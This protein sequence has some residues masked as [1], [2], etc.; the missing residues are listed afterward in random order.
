MA[1]RFSDHFGQLY[2]ER[3]PDLCAAMVQP[4]RHVAR[5]NRFFSPTLIS[6]QVQEILEEKSKE[7]F[8]EEVA[9]TCKPIIITRVDGH[10][11]QEQQESL[12]IC[13][14]CPESFP[15]PTASIEGGLRPYY[16]MDLASII[17]AV[18]LD[19]KPDHHVADFCA[20]PGK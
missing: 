17:V 4:Q 2:G 7:I 16:I 19:V 15:P 18:A 3:W 1:Q 5:L 9:A 10:E 12:P 13:Y 11:E 6:R 20:A 14:T 8:G